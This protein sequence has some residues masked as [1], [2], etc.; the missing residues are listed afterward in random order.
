MNKEISLKKFLLVLGLLVFVELLIYCAV[1]P[2]KN[3]QELKMH[4]TEKT[5]FCNEDN[6]ICYNYK[7]ENNAQVPT[8]K[9]DCSAFYK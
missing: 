5:V 4:C 9:G 1:I 3:H 6:T 8:W 2:I 7:M